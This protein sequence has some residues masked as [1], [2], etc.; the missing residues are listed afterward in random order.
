M[1]RKVEQ[2]DPLPEYAIAVNRD[3]EN[4]SVTLFWKTANMPRTRRGVYR[5]AQA[6]ADHRD[7]QDLKA[8]MGN[9]G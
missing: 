8:R 4:T 7:L 9:L 6:T 3:P 2:E 1:L 5:S